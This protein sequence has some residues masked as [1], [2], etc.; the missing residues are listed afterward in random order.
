MH[1]PFAHYL[2]CIIRIEHVFSPFSVTAIIRVGH[3]PH[4]PAVDKFTD[5]SRPVHR[6]SHDFHSKT[7]ACLVAGG[8]SAHF[9]NLAK[10]IKTIH[11]EWR[12]E[13]WHFATAGDKLGHG[14]AADRR[15]LKAPGSPTGV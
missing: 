13:F 9:V 4:L 15:S 7:L 1:P 14:F 10:L 2:N 3:F 5:I 8:G 12:D 6:A 11:C